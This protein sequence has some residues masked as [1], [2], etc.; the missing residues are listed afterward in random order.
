MKTRITIDDTVTEILPPNRDFDFCIIH[1]VSGNEVFFDYVG[2]GTDL[3]ETNG[4]PH[5]DAGIV[6]QLWNSVNP[7]SSVFMNG[8]YAVCA[9]GESATVVVQYS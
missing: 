9:S 3:T 6:N 1:Y 5:S 8:I 4:I 2:G 7:A